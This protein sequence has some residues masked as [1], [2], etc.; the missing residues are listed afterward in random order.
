MVEWL[1]DQRVAVISGAGRRVGCKI[2]RAFA[3]T[4]GGHDI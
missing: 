3:D 1:L 2:A 4:G